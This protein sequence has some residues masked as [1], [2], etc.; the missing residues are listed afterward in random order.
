MSQVSRRLEVG[1]HQRRTGIRWS[2][3]SNKYYI[4]F[5]ALCHYNRFIP[6][7]FAKSLRMMPCVD[8][9]SIVVHSSVQ[10]LNTTVI[11]Y[12]IDL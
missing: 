2:L 7:D 11:L 10:E 12:F 6:S 9:L 4:L 8:V 5:L 3:R 1:N